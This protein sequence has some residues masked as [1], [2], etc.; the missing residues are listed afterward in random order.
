MSISTE[1]EQ[2]VGFHKAWR[3]TVHFQLLPCFTS[4]QP[5]FLRVNGMELTSASPFLAP[6]LLLQHRGYTLFRDGFCT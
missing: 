2:L 1:M 3:F 6:L 4:I 5:P